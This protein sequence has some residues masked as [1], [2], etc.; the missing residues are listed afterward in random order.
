MI[1]WV[2]VFTGRVSG[3]GDNRRRACGWADVA[4]SASKA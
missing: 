4:A 3:S 2:E 1:P